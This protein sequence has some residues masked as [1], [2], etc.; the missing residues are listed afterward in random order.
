M[1][2]S[3]KKPSSDEKTLRRAKAIAARDNRADDHA[4]VQS[5]CH[6]LKAGAHDADKTTTLRGH[7]PL[8]A[9]SIWP[10]L[11]QLAGI[12]TL[13][14]EAADALFAKTMRQGELFDRDVVVKPHTRK[15][16]GKPAQ[17][18]QSTRHVAGGH[19][20]A[21]EHVRAESAYHRYRGGDVRKM[22]ELASA[23]HQAHDRAAGAA[24]ERGD[25][26]TGKKHGALANHWKGWS[27]FHSGSAARTAALPAMTPP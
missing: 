5:I 4:Y 12:V 6:R 18:K 26:K 13:S 7:A 17:V 21:P 24:Y 25:T 3:V 27:E 8:V 22:S 16:D 1:L 20:A 19:P 9:K 2:G 10:E 11:V 14:R 23:A 15:R